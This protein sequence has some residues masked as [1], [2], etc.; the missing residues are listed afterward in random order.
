M[1]YI[2]IQN[3]RENCEELNKKIHGDFERFKYGLTY[4][5]DLTN[6]KISKDE[7]FCIF[8]T[9]KNLILEDVDSNCQI[10]LMGGFRR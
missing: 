6:N 9:I 4:Y 2:D 8:E 5:D 10:E 1:G 7:A 3:L